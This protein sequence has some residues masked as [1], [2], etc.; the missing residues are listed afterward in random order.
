M[1]QVACLPPSHGVEI[2]PVQKENE[3]STHLSVVEGP[4]TEKTTSVVE[5]EDKLTSAVQQT[6]TH[7]QCT[8]EPLINDTP[9]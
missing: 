4:P 1:L 8:V 6:L 5:K 9:Y 7:V 3:I 2:Q